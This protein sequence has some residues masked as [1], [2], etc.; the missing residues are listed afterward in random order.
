MNV[1]QRQWCWTGSVCF[2]WGGSEQQTCQDQDRLTLS[3]I[4]RILH[5]SKM[6]WT[7]CLTVCSLL[8]ELNMSV[9]TVNVIVFYPGI[10]RHV[11][12]GSHIY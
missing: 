9:I 5:E 7:G 2:E 6:L 3:L 10:I 4:W 12:T 1:Y 8:V 11:P